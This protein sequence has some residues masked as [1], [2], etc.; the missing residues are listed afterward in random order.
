VKALFF[1]CLAVLLLFPA[2]GRAQSDPDQNAPVSLAAAP[3]VNRQPG[4][5]ASP[6]PQSPVLAEP[7]PVKPQP[8]L[9]LPVSVWAASVA[10]DQATTYLF[11]SRYGDVLH[12]KNFLI[13]GLDRNPAAL[14]AAGTAI[15]AA[16]GWV[17]YRLL[18][19]HPKLA[20]VVFYGAAAYRGYLA[21]YNIRMMRRAQAIRATTAPAPVVR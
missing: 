14:V 4:V 15:D 5:A 8:S 1:A 19:N 11:S 9:R 7:A 20:A 13:R 21:A 16:T 2:N 17:A 12:E 18:R 3:Q 6:V 10:A